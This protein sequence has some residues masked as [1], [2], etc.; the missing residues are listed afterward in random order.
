MAKQPL[1]KKRTGWVAD[2]I[3][4]AIAAALLGM[5]LA[6]ANVAIAIEADT[7]ALKATYTG[8]AVA[9]VLVPAAVMFGVSFLDRRW[10]D[11]RR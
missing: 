3:R 8:L 6:G 1:R 4:W 9:S 5:I 7:G 10:S 2:G 11:E